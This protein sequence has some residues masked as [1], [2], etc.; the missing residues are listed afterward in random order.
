MI[1]IFKLA[2]IVLPIMLVLDFI[3]I[4][5]IATNFYK[6]EYGSLYTTHTVWVAVVIFYL[7]YAVGFAYFVLAPALER[8][9]LR[10]ALFRGMFLAFIAFGTYDLTSLAVTANWS[11]LLSIVDMSWGIVAGAVTGVLSYLIAS[12]ILKIH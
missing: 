9:S 6:V 3:W 2:L 5:L 11:A 8:H 7:M 1:K 12:K 4:G 10:L